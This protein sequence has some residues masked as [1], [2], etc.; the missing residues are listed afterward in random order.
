MLRP[1]R[2]QAVVHRLAE[3]DRGGDRSLDRD[4]LDPRRE[5]Q[6]VDA[7]GASLREHHVHVGEL[8]DHRIGHRRC[9]VPDEDMA[10]TVD[11]QLASPSWPLPFGSAIAP[12]RYSTPISG[13][14]STSRPLPSSRTRPFS[15][16]TPWV[17]SRRPAR[18]FC[19]TSRIVLPAARICRTAPNTVLSTFGDSPIDGSSRITRPGSSIRHLANSTSR[20]WPP[21]KLPALSPAQ[22]THSGKISSARARRSASSALLLIV[23]P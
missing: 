19:S 10:V 23:Y 1:D 17:E 2:E 14:S 7:P 3:R 20:C 12:P 9:H 18:A 11:D 5:Q 16:T 4:E 13:C 6:V 15:S 21:D 22:L 8:A